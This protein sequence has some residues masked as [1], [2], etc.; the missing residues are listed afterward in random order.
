MSAAWDQ[1]QSENQPHGAAKRMIR[2]WG[3]LALAGVFLVYVA[4][5]LNIKLF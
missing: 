4:Y 1:G 2:L 5:S 3:Y